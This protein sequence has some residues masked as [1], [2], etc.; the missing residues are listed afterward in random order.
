[1]AISK[2]LKKYET[3]KYRFITYDDGKQALI[4]DDGNELNPV[5]V[6]SG[7]EANCFGHSYIVNLTDCIKIKERK[8][9]LIKAK[10]ITKHNQLFKK[11][12][13]FVA[14]VKELE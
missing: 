14:K 12:Q 5:D 6:F 10:K 8:I 3:N 7:C 4:V 9:S 1:M 13:Q 2:W 11:Y